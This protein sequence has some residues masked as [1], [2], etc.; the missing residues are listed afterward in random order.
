MYCIPKRGFLTMGIIHTKKRLAPSLKALRNDNAVITET[1]IKEVD[2]EVILER[3]RF[4]VMTKL[5]LK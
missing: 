1:Y 4:N 2:K 3:R 5:N